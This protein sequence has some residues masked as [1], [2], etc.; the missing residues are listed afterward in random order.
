MT[1]A[2]TTTE[3]SSNKSKM[4]RAL[5]KTRAPLLADFFQKLDRMMTGLPVKVI[6]KDLR[7]ALSSTDGKRIWLDWNVILK[8]Y[9]NEARLGLNARELAHCFYGNSNYDRKARSSYPLASN[10]LLECRD[11]TL[12]AETYPATRSYFIAYVQEVLLRNRALSDC[13]DVFPLLYGMKY[14]PAD[15][16]IVAGASFKVEWVSRVTDVIDKFVCL[17][18]NNKDV[19]DAIDLTIV[20][21]ALLKEQSNTKFYNPGGVPLLRSL[22]EANEVQYAVSN[23]RIIINND[24]RALAYKI[25]RVGKGKV[26]AAGNGSN[27]CEFGGVSRRTENLVD[28]N[29]SVT[30]EH[31]GSARSVDVD[32]LFEIIEYA[33]RNTV[34]SSSKKIASLENTKPREDKELETVRND[35]STTPTPTGEK[36]SATSGGCPFKAV[37]IQDDGETEVVDDYV[38]VNADYDV[39]KLNEFKDIVTTDS[40][41]DILKTMEDEVM[42]DDPLLQ[43][44]GWQGCGFVNAQLRSVRRELDEE[45]KL[46][47]K[48]LRSRHGVGKRGPININ[49]AMKAESGNPTPNIF[50]TRKNYSSRTNLEAEIVM[51]I[52]A[53][54]SMTG[55][56]NNVMKTQWLIGSAFEHLGGNVTV[57]PFNNMARDPLKGRMDKYSDHVYPYC[58]ADGGTQ[59][60]GALSVALDIFKKAGRRHKILF[61]LTD[62]CWN[63]I[64]WAHKLIDQLN[65]SGVQTVMMFMGGDSRDAAQMEQSKFHHCKIGTKINNIDELL[66]E[67]RRVFFTEFKRAITKSLKVYH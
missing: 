35:D 23:V 58:P 22:C 3:S 27:N 47:A 66:P 59:P 38:W 51:L 5:D 41:R 53:S 18:T 55:V 33:D 4:K 37:I 62:G 19:K 28:T 60:Q 29:K 2:L 13:G 31:S 64:D 42:F 45:L 40:V 52:D 50:K 49:A 10:I 48:K 6:I 7:T 11:M 63:D 20:F 54:G 56:I 65:I 46:T 15:L 21:D 26:A 36:G 67:M 9:S 1:A 24:K 61:M 8:E 44:A 57:I 25:R 32:A 17:G 39:T 43:K 12:F 34:N 16:R 30:Y 14:L